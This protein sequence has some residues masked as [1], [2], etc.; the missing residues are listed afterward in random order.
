MIPTGKVTKLMKYRIAEALACFLF[1]TFAGGFFP[2]L[3]SSLPILMSAELKRFRSVLPDK[4]YDEFGEPTFFAQDT[5]P[6]AWLNSLVA[7]LVVSGHPFCGIFLG[8]IVLLD[9][10]RDQIDVWDFIH[11]KVASVISRGRK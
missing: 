1:F 10:F 9:F 3:F 6:I 2:A 11:S 7:I 8:I 5:V 4:F